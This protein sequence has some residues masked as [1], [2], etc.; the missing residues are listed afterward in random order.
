MARRYQNGNRSIGL[1]LSPRFRS[2]LAFD[3]GKKTSIFQMFKRDTF[4]FE[5]FCTALQSQL[6]L[7]DGLT[8]IS[9]VLGEP[10][11]RNMSGVTPVT[12]LYFVSLK[13]SQL[14][15]IECI[16]KRFP[17]WKISEKGEFLTDIRLDID[18]ENLI[19][20]F[21]DFETEGFAFKIAEDEKLAV[22]QNIGSM[23]VSALRIT[24]QGDPSID[25][26][27]TALINALAE[28]MQVYRLEI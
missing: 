26:T 16:S 3:V 24:D 21:F 9:D 23:D 25:E 18:A 5:G 10:N 15:L 1:L 28:H 7:T 14:D 2:C 4:D 20:I 17:D 8:E 13:I 11:L 6:F 19:Y 27:K 22:V 12:D